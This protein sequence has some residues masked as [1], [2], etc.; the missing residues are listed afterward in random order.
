MG[1]KKKSNSRKHKHVLY[2][3]PMSDLESL[4]APEVSIKAAVYATTFAKD[5]LAWMISNQANIDQ[6]QA[7]MKDRMRETLADLPD[8]GN[9][10]H[11]HNVEKAIDLIPSPE[12]VKRALTFAQHHFER[13]Y[14]TLEAVF[15]DAD[16]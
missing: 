15:G 10:N 9:P 14:D 12:T 13:Q 4:G 5:A 1:N 16:L 3:L 7:W 11:P 8:C 2:G 6:F